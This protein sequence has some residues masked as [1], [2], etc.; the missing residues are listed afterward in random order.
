VK[1]YA[2]PDVRLITVA[3]VVVAANVL[4]A[5][6]VPSVQDNNRP[7]TLFT[8]A[9][10][11][12]QFSVIAPTPAIPVLAL[13]ETGATVGELVKPAVDPAVV[14]LSVCADTAN[15]YV[16]LAFKTA[17]VYEVSVAA[18]GTITAARGAAAPAGV[19]VMETV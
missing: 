18:T 13:K 12:A 15:A 7:L 4:L 2:T 8:L 14:P 16:E 6:V 1:V 3:P 9:G 17:V 19:S 10:L 5:A 11:F